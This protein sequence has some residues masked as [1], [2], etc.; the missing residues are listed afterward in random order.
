M[1]IAH[2][3]GWPSGS[4]RD[5]LSTA[6][7]TSGSSCATITQCTAAAITYPFWRWATIASIQS[8]VRS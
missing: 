4:I 7:R 6:S 5:A 8:I 2:T 1:F 3:S